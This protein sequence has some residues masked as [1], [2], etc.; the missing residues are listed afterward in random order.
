MLR[1]IAAPILTLPLLFLGFK[2][3]GVV[4]VTIAVSLLVDAFY[5]FYVKRRLRCKF[6]FRGFEKG[7]FKSLFA[8][9]AF[10]AI[11][12]LVDQINWNIDKFLLGR[13]RGTEAV[14]VYSV[15]Y[16]LYN[17][18][19]MFSSAVSGV[20]TPR[21]HKIV[22]ETQGN[23]NLQRAQL[24]TLFIKVG[25]IQYLRYLL[26]WG[27]YSI[28]SSVCWQ[29]VSYSSGNRLLTFGQGVDMGMRITLPYC[30]CCPQPLR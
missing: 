4:A 8:F 21:I 19:M 26:R 2:S 1:T 15:G 30:W 17:F 5:L 7:L 9:T 25:R 22:N 23:A 13:F 20:F 3:V 27:E 12:L 29:A 18:Y 28:S 16:A 14:A 24:S 10:I 11:N 6:I